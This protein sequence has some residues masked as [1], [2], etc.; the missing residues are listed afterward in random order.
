[1]NAQLEEELLEEPGLEPAADRRYDSFSGTRKA[2]MLL[3]SLGDQASA[4]IVSQL[5]EDEIQRVSKEVARI[6]SLSGGQVEGVLEEFYNLT[7]ASEYVVRGG[8]RY[9]RKMLVAVF[10]TDARLRLV[11]ELPKDIGKSC[12]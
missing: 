7:L 3:I 2:A 9:A 6:K 4:K 10:D 8:V 1:M 12:S 11:D 5:S